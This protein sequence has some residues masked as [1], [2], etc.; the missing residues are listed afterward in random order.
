[1]RR[2]KKLLALCLVAIELAVTGGIRAEAAVTS[3]SPDWTEYLV[4]GTYYIR[5]WGLIGM[6]FD[7]AQYFFTA[8]GAQ[9]FE[10]P[11]VN[12][13]VITTA[14]VNS[15]IEA[16]PCSVPGWHVI[17]SYSNK[18]RVPL[19]TTQN[20]KR[21]FSFIQT[22]QLS[23]AYLPNGYEAQREAT[24]LEEL[25]QAIVQLDV[26]TDPAVIS[27]LCAQYYNTIAAGADDIRNAWR[28]AGAWTPD[29]YV[30]PKVGT[31]AS[32]Y[33]NTPNGQGPE[34]LA[35]YFLHTDIMKF[36]EPENRKSLEYQSHLSE[37][38]IRNLPFP[39]EYARRY[40][41]E[42]RIEGTTMTY[43]Y[44]YH[45]SYEEEFGAMKSACNIAAAL[46][47][48]QVPSTV[49]WDFDLTPRDT[50]F[51]E[52]APTLDLLMANKATVMNFRFFPGAV[53]LP[54]DSGVAVSWVAS[55]ITPELIAGLESKYHAKVYYNITGGTFMGSKRANCNMSVIYE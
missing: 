45:G 22:S 16:Y 48:Y 29:D 8:E 25:G 11:D 14:A 23:P 2:W 10:Y 5:E 42:M 32:A 35:T 20:P 46:G 21:Y 34:T 19:G 50:K 51:Y 30:Y 52:A 39:R 38:Y 53:G 9:V 43:P 3:A 12:S 17:I 33:R 49:D 44:Y 27:Q 18:Y 37:S 24:Q 7:A 31:P 1:M 40:G 36:Y 15:W 55:H 47:E 54:D 13:R 41:N 4:P 28:R 6:E 26:G